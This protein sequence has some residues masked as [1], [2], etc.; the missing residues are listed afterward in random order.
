M[1]NKERLLL[2]E[3]Q[4]DCHFVK[5]FWDKQHKGDRSKLLFYEGEK[6]PFE[7]KTLGGVEKLCE[8][9]PTQITAPDREVLGIPCRCKL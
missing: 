2:V 7:I 4:D 5:Q 3:G 8:N 6:Q 9:I 1:P